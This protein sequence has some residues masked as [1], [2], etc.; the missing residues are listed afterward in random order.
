MTQ[1]SAH[2]ACDLQG[3]PTLYDVPGSCSHFKDRAAAVCGLSISDLKSLT[4][5]LSKSPWVQFHGCNFPN[6]T[7]C[8]PKSCDPCSGMTRSTWHDKDFLADITEVSRLKIYN[9]ATAESVK[10]T[11]GRAYLKGLATNAT[12]LH[13]HRQ[14][15]LPWSPPSNKTSTFLSK[16]CGV[17]AAQRK[18]Q[19]A[20]PI[21]F[22]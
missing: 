17:T 9:L 22:L 7:V 20:L 14:K 21:K 4:D 8:L 11:W 10:H 16:F 18:Q 1:A 19:K 13:A 2:P 12:L 15:H 3:F 6:T 5:R